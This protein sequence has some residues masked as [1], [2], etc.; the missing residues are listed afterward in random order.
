MEKLPRSLIRCFMF[1]IICCSNLWRFMPLSVIS[2]KRTRRIFSLRLAKF[3]WMNSSDMISSDF[4]DLVLAL[5]HDESQR[6][7]FWQALAMDCAVSVIS[8]R[9]LLSDKLIRIVHSAVFRGMPMASKTSDGPFLC[10]EQAD[11]VDT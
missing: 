1:R 2:P 11:P 8:S 3:G 5:M 7:Y 6:R 9:V 4:H 10:E